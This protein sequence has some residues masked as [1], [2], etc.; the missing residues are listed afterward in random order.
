MKNTRWYNKVA[1]NMNGAPV[2]SLVAVVVLWFCVRI[3]C[4]NA[5]VNS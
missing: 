5:E 2:S 3:P 4:V 1:R